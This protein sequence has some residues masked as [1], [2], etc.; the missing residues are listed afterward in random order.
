M[1][2][3]KAYRWSPNTMR[4][5]SRLKVMNE[6]EGWTETAIIEEAIHNLFSQKLSA[7]LWHMNVQEEQIIAALDTII[8]NW[9]DKASQA[10]I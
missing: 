5:L 10:G 7:A 9:D 3:P 4:Y 6:Y 2:T 1:K 8:Q